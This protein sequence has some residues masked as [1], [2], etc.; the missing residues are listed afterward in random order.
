MQNKKVIIAIILCVGAVI[1]LIY[2]LTAGPK[3]KRQS[4]PISGVIFQDKTVSSAGRIVLIKRRAIKTDFTSWG[5]SP[6]TLKK[7]TDTR[8]TLNGIL[9]D[10]KNPQ[11]IIKGEIVEVGDKIGPNIVVDIKQDRVILSDG[12]QDFELKLGY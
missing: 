6:F 7:T 12:T 3:S 4:V 8:L 1:S 9:W 11:A 5:R 2:G 10:A